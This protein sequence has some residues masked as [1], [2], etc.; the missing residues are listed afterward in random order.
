MVSCSSCGRHVTMLHSDVKPPGS[1][2]LLGAAMMQPCRESASI[3]RLKPNTKA[4]FEV[5][6][7]NVYICESVCL[8]PMLQGRLM[9]CRRR[10][11]LDVISSSELSRTDEPAP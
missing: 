5:R 11:G 9:R 7:S 8:A 2:V 4:A 3:E 6:G 10:A 1:R